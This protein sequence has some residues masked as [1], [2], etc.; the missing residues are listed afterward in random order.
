[1]RRSYILHTFLTCSLLMTAACNRTEM[2]YSGQSADQNS[3]R[4]AVWTGPG[5]YYGVWFSTEFEFNDYH[6]RHYSPRNRDRDRDHDDERSRRSGDD[7]IP[8]GRE[9]HNFGRGR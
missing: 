9:N 6:E 3:S 5:F 4:P 8:S 2:S 1:M 7:S